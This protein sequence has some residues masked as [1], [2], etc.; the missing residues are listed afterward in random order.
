MGNRSILPLVSRSNGS[1]LV[2]VII[3]AG[4]AGLCFEIFQRMSRD[5]MSETEL[6]H[7]QSSNLEC[8]KEMGSPAMFAQGS[9]TPNTGDS[10]L[11][12]GLNEM[13]QMYVAMDTGDF[14]RA[15]VQEGKL[16]TFI[17]KL[18]ARNAKLNEKLE[19]LEK[20]D[21]VAR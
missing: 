13:H 20:T 14:A 1:V 17:E 5:S 6:K 21:K 10:E 8:L 15:K 4:L 18:Q 3:I 9:F 12:N 11:D 2:F 7:I 19:A 16:K